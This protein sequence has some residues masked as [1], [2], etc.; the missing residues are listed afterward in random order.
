MYDDYLDFLAQNTNVP[1]TPDKELEQW[2]REVWNDPEEF[3]KWAQE[4]ERKLKKL[5]NDIEG[6]AK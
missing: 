3:E 2:E 5:N 4:Q 1:P 6:T